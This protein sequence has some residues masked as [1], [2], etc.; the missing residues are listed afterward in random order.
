MHHEKPYLSGVQRWETLV[1]L[2][3]LPNER[4]RKVIY[5]LYIEDVKPETLAR[6]LDATTSI[7]SNGGHWNN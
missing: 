5:A 3:S 7:T 4:Y 6:Q 2:S 1:Y